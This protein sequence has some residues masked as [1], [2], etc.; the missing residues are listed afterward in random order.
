MYIYVYVCVYEYML[1]PGWKMVSVLWLA[2]WPGPARRR[3]FSLVGGVLRRLSEPE[4]AGFCME[5][6]LE[7][8]YARHPSRLS[9]TYLGVFVTHPAIC[10]QST[11][12]SPHGLEPAK[13]G[14]RID[15]A[16]VTRTGFRGKCVPIV[17]LQIHLRGM[18]DEVR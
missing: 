10:Y 4:N 13:I 12:Q 15:L 17:S 9:E 16:E 18:R 7:E 5:V 8:R 11:W 3:S 1:Y 14:S 6:G 2:C